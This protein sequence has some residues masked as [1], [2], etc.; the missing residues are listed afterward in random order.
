MLSN[1]EKRLMNYE[2][3]NSLAFK[4]RKKRATIVMRLIAE[5]YETD[6]MVNI[7][8]IGGTRTYWNIIF[9]QFLIDHK[10]HISVVNLPSQ[11]P[12]PENDEIFSFYYGNGCNLVEFKDHSFHIAH[13]NSVIEHV[14]DWENVVAFSKEL[15]RVAQSYY[16][17]TPNYWFPLEPHFFMP[18]F[19]WFPKTIRIKMISHFDLG[20]NI[21][22]MDYN[23]ARIRIEHCNLLTK[24]ELKKLFPESVICKEKF[25]CFTKSWILINKKM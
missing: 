12:L 18:F 13:S 15:K 5:F 1:I 24:G 6:G 19:Q 7:I 21:K 20:H 25:L 23:N 22:M 16:L 2:S 3:G 4:L 10:V 11:E 8:D 14:G 9:K 17:Q